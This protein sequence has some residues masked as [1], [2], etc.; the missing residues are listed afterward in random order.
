MLST[1]MSDGRN[2][3]LVAVSMGRTKDAQKA[4]VAVAASADTL[5]RD[6]VDSMHQSTTQLGRTVNKVNYTRVSKEEMSRIRRIA[7]E[8]KDKRTAKGIELGLRKPRPQKTSRIATLSSRGA[9]KTAIVRLLGLLD[10][11]KNGKWCRYESYCPAFRRTGAHAGDTATH[12]CPQMRGDAARFMPENVVWGCA[13]AN[14]G[15]VMNRSLYR[16]IHIKLFGKDRIEAI[17]AVART[18]R[19]YTTADL[20]ELRNNLRKQV[21]GNMV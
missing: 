16:D 17:E 20:I 8:K 12:L 1:M 15:E 4:A 9:I 2:V 19:K 7:K 11:K 10:M 5:G 14:Y 21:S 13:A 18:T 3:V 6:A